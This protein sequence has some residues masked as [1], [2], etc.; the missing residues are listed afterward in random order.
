MKKTHFFQTMNDL[1]DQTDEL[2]DLSKRIKSQQYQLKSFK[3]QTGNK[4][5]SLLY[6]TLINLNKFVII[7]FIW[8]YY[9]KK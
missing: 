1:T 6:T 2:N 7:K 4:T 9:L 8:L 3:K 5:L